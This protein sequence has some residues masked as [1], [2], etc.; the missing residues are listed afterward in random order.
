MKDLGKN[1]VS[2]HRIS[3]EAGGQRIDN[4]LLKILKGVP[5]SHVYRILRSG[6]V[7]VN[8]GR[9]KPAY[10]LR[11]GDELRL[12]PVRVAA[13]APRATPPPNAKLEH[14]ILYEDE[15]LLVLNKPSGLAVHGGSGISFGV[16]EQLRSQR[17][18]ARFLE[19]VHRLD[20]D[21]SGLLLLAKK[22]SALTAL[23]TELRAGRVK[24]Y[25]LTLVKGKWRNAKQSVRLNLHKY[26][27]ASGERRVAVDTEGEASH[28]VFDLQQA[29]REFSLLR[30]ELKTGRT[31][32]IR[33]HLAHLGYPIAGD[34]KYGDFAFNKD[35]A[36]A[37]LKRMFLHASRVSF[38]HPATETMLTLEAPLPDE[39]QNFLRTLD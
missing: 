36:R 37:G 3:E 21:T 30:A 27:L 28:T 6:E 14:A 31:H 9:A 34:D 13:Q 4:Y 8:S 5:K 24:K 29:W 2:R 11:P 17:P 12:P 18:L 38:K 19:L 7:R 33:V 25:Y 35:L 20:R 32:Q 10:R 23:H 39:L 15:H 16:I 1:S 26:V 22:R